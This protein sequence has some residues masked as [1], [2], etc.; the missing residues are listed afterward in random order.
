MN[1]VMLTY[2]EVKGLMANTLSCDTPP[3]GKIKLSEW[4]VENKEKLGKK[5]TREVVKRIS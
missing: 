2:D 5:Y 1:D 3:T 4:I